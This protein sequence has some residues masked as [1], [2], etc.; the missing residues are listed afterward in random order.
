MAA[1]PDGNG[2]WMVA[3]DGGIF[4]FGDA[5]F[6]GSMGG[7]PLNQPIVG[8]AADSQT[9]GYWFVAADGGAFNFNA[10]FYGSQGGTPPNARVVGI[11]PSPTGHGYWI[12]ASD[13]ALFNFGDALNQGSLLGLGDGGGGGATLTQCNNEALSLGSQANWIAFYWVF[14][15]GYFQY[16]VPNLINE[17]AIAY[18]Y[19][20]NLGCSFAGTGLLTPLALYVYYYG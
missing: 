1:T 11:A 16:L 13:G 17:Y 18:T 3:S 15:S 6:Y 14:D 19:F 8:M 20:H 5:H 2:Y 10:N 7:R 12:A 9:G 4:S